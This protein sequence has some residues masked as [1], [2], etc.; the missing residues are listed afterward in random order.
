MDY[1][2]KKEYLE[3]YQRHSKNIEALQM[4]YEKWETLGTKVTQSLSFAPAGGDEN[5]SKPERSG[6]ELAQIKE[7]I[8]KEIAESTVAR[9]KV[10]SAISKSK[11][12]RYRDILTYR[13]INGLNA[14]KISRIIGK[15]VRGTH[16]LI[17]NAIYDLDI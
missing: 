3:S 7:K 10:A 17:R 2:Q 6:I 12:R 8:M 11:K 15:E 9:E 5:T 1:R 13:Y 16:K 14:Y 4:E